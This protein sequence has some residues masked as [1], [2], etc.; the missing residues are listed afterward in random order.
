MTKERDL[1]Q[2]EFTLA[3]LGIQLIFSEFL[4]NKRQMFVV[5]LLIPRIYQNIIDEHHHEL[6]KILHEHLGHQIHEISWNITVYSQSPYL[7]V[8]AVF[9]ISEGR[10]L[11]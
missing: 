4:Q 1:S 7:V 10:I 9:A 8:K 3:E 2:P 5:F 6:V 11:S